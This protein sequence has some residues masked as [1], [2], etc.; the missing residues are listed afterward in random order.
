MA[1]AFGLALL[2]SIIMA[3]VAYAQQADSGANQQTGG[4][5]TAAERPHLLFLLQRPTGATAKR[6]DPSSQLSVTLRNALDNANRFNIVVYG[7]EQPS[8]KRALLEHTIPVS[9]LVEPIRPEAFRRIAQAIGARYTLTVKSIFDRQGVKTEMRY[10]EN[11]DGDNWRTAL[12]E[13]IG[14]DAD[15]GKRH[16]K[17]SDLIALTVDAICTRLNVPSHLANKIDVGPAKVVGTT[18]PDKK[19]AQNTDHKTDKS[20]QVAQN[21]PDVK[22]GSAPPVNTQPAVT[23]GSPSAGGPGTQDAG[24]NKGVTSAPT[25]TTAPNNASKKPD[26]KKPTKSVITPGSNQSSSQAADAGTSGAQAQRQSAKPGRTKPASPHPIDTAPVTPPAAAPAHTDYV[27]LAMAARKDGDTS[28]TITLLRKAVTAAPHDATLRQQLIQ[29]YQD[30]HMTDLALSEAERAIQ[31]MPTDNTLQRLYGDALLAKGDRAGALKI[32]RDVVQRDPADVAAQVALADAL[33]AD[34]Q[35]A[36]ALTAYLAAAK[37]DPNSPLPHRRLARVYAGRAA[38][39]PTQ[40]QESLRELT[41]A[42]QMTPSADTDV[43]RDDYI[44]LMRQMEQRLRDSADELQSTYQAAVQGTHNI[45]EITRSTTD[46]K[47]R[48]TALGNFLDG[49]LPA[50]GQDGSLAHYRESSALLV[51]AIGAFRRVL[52]NSNGRIEDMQ[53]TLRVARVDILHEL[54]TAHK[55]LMTA[56]AD[57][58]STLSSSSTISG[59]RKP[60]TIQ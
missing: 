3:G 16:L 53:R 39:D 28:S 35:F 12:S 42:R 36:E 45:T 50:I 32:Y 21:S 4:S 38:A 47:E 1:T 13:Q 41:L 9:D 10:D 11:I 44:A 33:L 55:L 14:F 54:E 52:A 25:D 37:S 26:K 51:Q 27:A 19:N 23:G 57:V 46:L 34:N 60:E 6:D 59:N 56:P 18:K 22:I 48:A 30:R 29:A 8:I 24:S 17:T 20:V 40:Y 43:Y 15:Y 5:E 2:M 31:L 58:R 49:V 7:A